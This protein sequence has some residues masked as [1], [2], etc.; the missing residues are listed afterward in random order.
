MECP[1]CSA[2]TRVL[3]SRRAEGG[4]AVRRRR[5]CKSCGGRFTSF[6]R[7]EREPA[8]VLKRDGGRQPFNS[9]K[10]RGALAR[11]THK[12]EEQV[13]PADLDAIVNRI[14]VEVEHAGGELP[15]DRVRELCLDGLSRIDAGAYLQFAGVELSDLDSVRAELSRLDQRKDRDFSPLATVGSVRDGEDSRRPTPREQSRGDH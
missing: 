13:T 8:W 7:R 3:E 4:S 12:R 14:E 15:S 10:L 6:E 2:E 1:S 9:E 5:E 11:A